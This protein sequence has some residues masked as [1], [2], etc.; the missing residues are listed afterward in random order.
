MVKLA[1]VNECK[2]CNHDGITNT[3]TMRALKCS[4]GSLQYKLQCNRCGLATSNPVKQELLAGEQVEAWRHDISL[5][6]HEEREA[7]QQA[8]LADMRTRYAAYLKTPEWARKRAQVMQRANNTCEGC[9]TSR[10]HQ[11]HHKTYEHIGE[12]F[13]WELVAVCM[14]CHER[15][16][17]LDADKAARRANHYVYKRAI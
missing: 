3:Q 13:L 11:V 10:A 12:E 9:G 4:N 17:E 8:E 7:A 2:S 15:L 6:L 5:R 1:T 14:Q 16:H